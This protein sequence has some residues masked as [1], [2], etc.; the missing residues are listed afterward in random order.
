MRERKWQEKC[1]HVTEKSFKISIIHGNV[2]FV[3][4]NGR[5]IESFNREELRN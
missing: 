2:K 1:S 5:K 4:G 3:R